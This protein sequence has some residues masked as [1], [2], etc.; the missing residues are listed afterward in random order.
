[1]LSDFENF[2]FRNLCGGL[3]NSAQKQHFSF[4]QQERSIPDITAKEQYSMTLW[5]RQ[6]P[7]AEFACSKDKIRSQ[8]RIR[9]QVRFQAGESDSGTISCTGS[10]ESTEL[11]FKEGNQKQARSQEAGHQFHAGVMTPSIG[12]LQMSRGKPVRTE[13]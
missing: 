7:F 2:Q 6:V 11:D 10:T 1:M 12:S 5:F 9:K 8:D 3:E 4:Q 13:C